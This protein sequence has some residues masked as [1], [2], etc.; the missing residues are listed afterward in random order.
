[1]NKLGTKFTYNSGYSATL[2][3]LGCLE[4]LLFDFKLIS[5]FYINKMHALSFA[6]NRW[7]FELE[8]HISF[9]SFSIEPESVWRVSDGLKQIFLIQKMNATKYKDFWMRTKF[10]IGARN[11]R[12]NCKAL[13]TQTFF[14]SKFV[15]FYSIIWLNRMN[16]FGSPQT[17][18]FHLPVIYHLF[19]LDFWFDW[20][21][22]IE[23]ASHL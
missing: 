16:Y 14:N 22:S 11:Y 4:F 13:S 5:S 9:K 15:S 19:H 2:S 12:R 21:L 18:S 3:I 1:M 6:V 7:Y 23:F 17:I 20:F 10:H 8:K